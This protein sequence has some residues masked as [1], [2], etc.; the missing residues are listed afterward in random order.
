[1]RQLLHVS[2][3]H[4]GPHHLPPV[5]EGVRALVAERRPDLVVISGDL[6]QRA[7]PHQFRAA[8]AFVDRL[9]GELGV[10]TLTVPGNHDVPLYRIWERLLAPYGAYR[11]HFAAELEP[12]HEDE[13]MVVIG[14]NTAY[15][16]TLKDGR[17][18]RRQRRALAARLA[19]VPA[20]KAKIV[21][22]HHHLVPAPR[23]DNQRVLK[24]AWE[25]VDLLA[26]HGVELVLGGHQHQT[27]VASSEAYYPSG[28]PPVWL[29]HAGTTTSA[30]GR[31]C[32]RR[33]NTC[34]WIRLDERRLEVSHLGWDEQ[35]RRFAVW[36]RHRFPRRRHGEL[37][38]T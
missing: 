20:G 3:L 18:G 24:G 22:M 28:R 11:A 25:T 21:V 8:R 32:E 35:E 34:N 14:L 23:Y 38:A 7:K 29:I 15:N 17:I 27:Y 26:A 33:R 13:E 12:E 19:A 5:A 9:E 10:A 30:R 1:M 6:T 4:F 31:G 37:D 2:D 36:S 16:W